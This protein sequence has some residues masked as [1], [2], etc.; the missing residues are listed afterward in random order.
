M[1]DDESARSQLLAYFLRLELRRRS[2][3]KTFR[4]LSRR[5]KQWQGAWRDK[6]LFDMPEGVARLPYQV[7]THQFGNTLRCLLT[8]RS[9]NVRYLDTKKFARFVCDPQDRPDSVY[10]LLGN[11]VNTV[12]FAEDNTGTELGYERDVKGLDLAR[13]GGQL[14]GIIDPLAQMVMGRSD[15]AFKDCVLQNAAGCEIF[16]F[17][18]A[19]PGKT[20]LTVENGEGY[21]RLVFQTGES[22]STRKGEEDEDKR[23]M[24]RYKHGLDKKLIK[25]WPLRDLSAVYKKQ[26][27]DTKTGVELTFTTGASVLLNFAEE[28]ERDTFCARALKLRERLIKDHVELLFDG[29]RSAEKSH[30][31]EDWCNHNVSTM[32]YLLWVNA[33]SSR[34]FDNSSQ[35]PVFPW[36]LKDHS[37]AKLLLGSP[38][39]YRDLTKSVGM[40]GEPDRAA[41]FRQRILQED[42]TGVGHF[43]YGSHYSSPGIVLQFH[44]RLHPFY[45]GYVQFFAGYDDPNRMF[46]S[47]SESFRSVCKDTSDVRELIPEFFALPEMLINSEGHRFGQRED[48]KQPVDHIVLPPWASKS[49]YVFASTARKALENDRASEHLHRWIDLVFG[50]Q[51]RGKEAEKAHNVFPPL[52]TDPAKALLAFKG[53]TQ[54]DFRVQAFHWG[55]TPQ[56]L[57]LHPHPQRLKLSAVP[58]CD[59]RANIKVYCNNSALQNELRVYSAT[60]VGQRMSPPASLERFETQQAEGK[61]VAGRTVCESMSGVRFL[62]VSAT[63]IIVEGTAEISDGTG[64]KGAISS[65]I[66]VM[67][68]P[69]NN[70]YVTS[71]GYCMM[72]PR[73][74]TNYPIAIVRRRGAEQIVQAGYLTGILR[75]TPLME[76]RNS[77][78]ME[79][80]RYPIT[81][82]KVDG[83]EHLGIT[84]DRSGE[85]A[86]HSIVD[87]STWVT[88]AYM[89]DHSEEVTWIDASSE[90]QLFATASADG[91]ANLYTRARRPKLIRTFRHQQGLPIH[92]VCNSRKKPAIGVSGA[93]SAAVRGDLQQDGQRV[94]LLRD[95]RDA[96]SHPAGE[97][98]GSDFACC[99]PRRQLPELP[100][101]PQGHREPDGG[102]K[103]AQPRD[104]QDRPAVP[105]CHLALSVGQP[106][107]RPL[108]TRG[109]DLHSCGQPR[110]SAEPAKK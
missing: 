47:M 7:S 20:M 97:H 4:K 49:P 17:L 57:F 84:G 66:Q 109:R 6:K 103:T 91:S 8:V 29:I 1:K 74:G 105:T 100:G 85:C 46:H 72:N 15:P 83:A 95:Q 33:L 58:L 19:K 51:Q 14:G 10:A 26:V 5:T 39:V 76:T 30:M 65:V 28:A 86:V 108:R 69:Y 3:A 70:H 12:A 101:L 62:M 59:K 98:Q 82:L 104:G 75:I 107:L 13:F 50:F 64:R 77:V 110:R 22:R 35:Y 42:I 25:K 67:P 21:V 2:C 93:K 52:S 90:M 89:C 41:N 16:T 78:M 102:A 94:L 55:Q 73:I 60:V 63:G 40:M 53:E 38:E 43:N 54:D 56:Q 27:V 34:S 81:C 24:F 44:M 106:G 48:D 11:V 18:L 31:A 23:L 79:I 92:Y 87:N 68:R 9:Q 88:T 99:G 36:V 71:D 45:E 37:S 61:I 80:H 96:A 32:D